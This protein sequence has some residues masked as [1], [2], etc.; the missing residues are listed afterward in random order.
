MK[1]YLLLLLVAIIAGTHAKAQGFIELG[2]MTY[3]V[4]P[5]SSSAGL[6]TQ[7]IQYGE[8]ELTFPKKLNDHTYF[9]ISMH[10]ELY[11]L[12]HTQG[13]TAHHEFYSLSLRVGMLKTFGKHALSIVFIPKL[14]SDMASVSGDDFQY[15]L[16]A[17]YSTRRSPTFQQKFGFY[18]NT[19]CFGLYVLPLYGID[20][21]M[22]DNFRFYGTLPI[23]ADLVY[24]HQEPNRWM[25]SFLGQNSTY[26]LGEKE[27]NDYVWRQ[28]SQLY[29]GYERKLSEHLFWQF[30]VGTSLG[31]SLRR[32]GHDQGYPIAITGLLPFGPEQT[33]QDIELKDQIL[34]RSSI[35]FRIST[36]TKG[37]N[38]Q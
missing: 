37:G 15:G 30:K 21:I 20:W 34:L 28:T 13:F 4:S 32:F 10:H 33:A 29:L 27:Q 7:P 5:N 12:Q 18:V 24:H 19:D 25:I 14:N 23:N 17:T 9:L 38:T 11:A 2:N 16:Y 26:R 3:Q 36:E 35:S 31:R 1:K 22:G 6:P 8:M